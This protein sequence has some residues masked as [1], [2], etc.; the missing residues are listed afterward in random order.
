[1]PLNAPLHGGPMLVPPPPPPPRPPAAHHAHAHHRIAS[2]IEVCVHVSHET[3]DADID[4]HHYY[5]MGDGNDLRHW[6]RAG[7]LRLDGPFQPPEALTESAFRGHKVFKR[8][9]LLTEF[10][11][12]GILMWKVVKV[13][14]SMPLTEQ[15]PVPPPPI[16][17][18]ELPDEPMFG[19]DSMARDGVT[20]SGPRIIRLRPTHDIKEVPPILKIHPVTRGV[21]QVVAEDVVYPVYCDPMLP[22]PPTAHGRSRQPSAHNDR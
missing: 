17:S 14:K 18:A 22:P 7:T 6:G 1:M 8:M 13:P 21:R 12:Q 4:Q 19:H 5:V 16:S 9:I 11:P 2:L 3:G 10:P 15:S 20:C